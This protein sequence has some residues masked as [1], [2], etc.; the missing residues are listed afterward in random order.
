MKKCNNSYLEILSCEFNLWVSVDIIDI[1]FKNG[2]THRKI[3][4]ISLAIFPHYAWKVNP[5]A[6]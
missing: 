4:K 1:M 3:L 2:Q 6:K 5:Y